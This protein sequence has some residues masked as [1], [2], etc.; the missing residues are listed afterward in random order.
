MIHA[1]I[2]QVVERIIG[3]DEV[4]GS[5]PGVSTTRCLSVVRVLPEGCLLLHVGNFIGKVVM[6][7]NFLSRFRHLLGCLK[8]I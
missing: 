3:N 6:G 8:I 2:A 4:P 5:T 1:R 7:F